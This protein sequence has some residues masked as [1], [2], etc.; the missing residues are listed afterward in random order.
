MPKCEVPCC[1]TWQILPYARFVETKTISCMNKMGLLLGSFEIKTYF[2][3]QMNIEKQGTMKNIF[4]V[5]L[6]AGSVFLAGCT[7]SL[8]DKA[9][10]EAKEYTMKVCPTPYVNDSRTDSAVFDKA[11]RTYTY[12]LSL[13]GKADN[14]EAIDANRKKLHDLQQTSL[15]N[16]PGLQKYKEAH[17]AFRFVYRS[18][19]NPEKV[20][21]DETFKY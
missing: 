5:M 9:A 11:T 15:D 4:C 16:N 17:F 13:R 18:D 2:C 3:M 14:K 1:S 6:L 10:R 21:L 8:E 20:L 19:A 12:Y 7:E